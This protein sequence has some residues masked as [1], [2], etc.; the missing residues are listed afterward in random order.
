MDSAF[1]G[2]GSDRGDCGERRWN[3]GLESMVLAVVR[4]AA[5][6]VDPAGL[7][8]TITREDWALY[9]AIAAERRQGSGA[10]WVVRAVYV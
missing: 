3:D 9:D 4:R 7:V 6:A 5:G 10:G 2:N 1:R 8:S